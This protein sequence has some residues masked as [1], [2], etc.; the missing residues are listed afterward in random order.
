LERIGIALA[1]RIDQ[2]LALGVTAGHGLVVASDG[3]VDRVDGRPGQRTRY[4]VVTGLPAEADW[5]ILS[6][7]GFLVSK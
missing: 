7:F 1:Q 4:R 3:N 5:T 2:G 6:K